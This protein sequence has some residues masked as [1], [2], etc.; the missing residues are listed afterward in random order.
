M[1]RASKTFLLLVTVFVAVRP[2]EA[3]TL[4]VY[5]IDVEGGAATLIVTPSGESLLVDSGFPLERDAQRIIH[6]VRD[7]ARLK[8]IDHYITTHWHRDH[9]GGIPMV[10]RAIHVEHFY[11]HGLPSNACL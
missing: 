6:V 2:A 3:R 9:V 10:A 1:R 11:D 5:F 7:V 8:Q 4:D